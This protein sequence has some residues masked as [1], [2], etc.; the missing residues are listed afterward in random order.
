EEVKDEE[1]EED[2]EEKKEEEAPKEEAKKEEAKKVVKTKKV[3]VKKL[4]KKKIQIP[5]EFT[6]PV[7]FS[8]SIP[9][10]VYYCGNSDDALREYYK[11][12]EKLLKKDHEVKEKETIYNDLEAFIYR[13]RDECGEYGSLRAFGTAKKCD[14]YVSEMN[15]AEEWLFDEGE[16]ATKDELFNK[17]AALRVYGDTLERLKREKEEAERKKK[18]EEERKIREKEE[19]KRKAEEEKKKKEEEKKA[20]KETKKAKK[21]EGEET[22]SKEEENPA[23]PKEEENN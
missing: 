2:K 23:S 16:F 17:L 22:A 14:A 8:T 1:K 11:I 9:H 10:Y 12:E 7:E 6:K 20:K 4:Q 15:D 3:K 5:H 18:E 21:D 19:K 13:M